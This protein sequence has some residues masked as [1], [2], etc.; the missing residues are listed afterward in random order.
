MPA[1]REELDRFHEF[2]IEQIEADTSQLNLQQILARWVGEQEKASIQTALKC[3][4]VEMK[5]GLGRDAWEVS[6]E[7]RQKFGIPQP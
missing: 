6:E 2:A 7:L 1:T 5:A 3:A 4:L